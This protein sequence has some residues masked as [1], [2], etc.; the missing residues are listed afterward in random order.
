MRTNSQGLFILQNNCI[1]IVA[2]DHLSGAPVASRSGKTLNL[3]P[4]FVHSTVV[5]RSETR[6]SSN[7][8][9]VEQRSQRTSI[10]D[11]PFKGC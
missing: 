5:P 4:Q 2:S 10:Q 1:K 9:S 7:S 11:H 8:Y 6:A 3:C